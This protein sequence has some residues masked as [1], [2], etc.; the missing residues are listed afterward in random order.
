MDILTERLT[1]KTR[2]EIRYCRGMQAM[3]RERYLEYLHELRLA[4]QRGN[5]RRTR[6]ITDDLRAFIGEMWHL[7]A[8][9]RSAY[10]RLFGIVVGQHTPSTI[11]PDSAT[12]QGE[13]PAN[14]IRLV[15]TR[16]QDG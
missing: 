10:G 7:V 11:M 5:A 4:R 8:Q 16:R 12:S 2:K 3:H 13:E 9:E 14:L 15:L 1:D 6:E